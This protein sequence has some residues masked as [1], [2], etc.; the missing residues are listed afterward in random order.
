[1]KKTT[2]IFLSIRF[3]GNEH[4]FFLT[5]CNKAKY[6]KV[7]SNRI[8]EKLVKKYPEGNKGKLTAAKLCNLNYS[9]NCTV[10]FSKS[11]LQKKLRA[12]AFLSFFFFFKPLS[13]N[14]KTFEEFQL[15][16]IFN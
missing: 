9:D 8:H 2:S 6:L 10:Q 5:S 16:R 13:L 12:P 4:L 15:E 14:K 7:L 1:M 3:T 11:S